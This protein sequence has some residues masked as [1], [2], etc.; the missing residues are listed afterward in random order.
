[1]VI[2]T[3]MDKRYRENQPP[4][5]GDWPALKERGLNEMKKAAVSCNCYNTVEMLNNKA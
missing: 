2:S 1:M 4:A 3:A 5:P